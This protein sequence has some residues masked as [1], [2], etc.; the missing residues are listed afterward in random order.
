MINEH[1]NDDF[2]NAIC[3]KHMASKVDW[4]RIQVNYYSN[5]GTLNCSELLFICLV[6]DDKVTA[7]SLLEKEQEEWHFLIP[8]T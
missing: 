7:E 6:K 5:Y 8:F 4:L 3:I 2:K 1:Y